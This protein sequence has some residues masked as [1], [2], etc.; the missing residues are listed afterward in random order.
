M[1]FCA[2]D[3]LEFYFKA[4]DPVCVTRVLLVF[5]SQN[6]GRVTALKVRITLKKRKERKKE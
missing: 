3:T 1:I 4:S 5:Y 2:V 6:S